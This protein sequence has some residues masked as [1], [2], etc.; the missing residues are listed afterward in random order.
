[1]CIHSI[2]AEI[3]AVCGTT[4]WISPFDIYSV[5]QKFTMKQKVPTQL[6]KLLIVDDEA[7]I[8]LLL[9]RVLSRNFD[10]IEHVLTIQQAMAKCPT[11]NPNTILLDNNLP[12]GSGIEEIALFKDTCPDAQIIIISAMTN[13]RDRAMENGASAF[14]EKPLSLK[15]ILDAIYPSMA[16]AKPSLKS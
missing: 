9:K 7:E 10:S 2:A 5:L 15:K 16:E 3:A 12:D 8:G 13:L 11:Y 1:M 14:V 4:P 6:K